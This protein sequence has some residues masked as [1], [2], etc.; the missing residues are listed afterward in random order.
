MVA[1]IISCSGPARPNPQRQALLPLS[2]TD[3]THEKTDALPKL[4]SQAPQPVAGHRRDLVHRGNLEPG[5]SHGRGPRMFR[6]I[7][8]QMESDGRRGA[9]KFPAFGCTRPGMPNRSAGV[10]RL[11]R[12]EQSGKQLDRPR[13]VRVGKTQ[14]GARSQGLIRARRPGCLRTAIFEVGLMRLEPS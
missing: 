2:S 3:F 8:R 9:E 6:G 14:R 4:E 1:A 11:V 5:E 10:L 12:A 7:V 13:R